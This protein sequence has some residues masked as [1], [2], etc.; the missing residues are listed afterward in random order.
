MTPE[1]QKEFETLF[2]LFVH[3]GWELFKREIQTNYSI[4]RDGTVDLDDKDEFLKRKGYVY[5]L[6]YALNF[7]ALIRNAYENKL[8]ENNEGL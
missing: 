8:Q 7:E 3:P 2:D 1:E 4:L 6:A 5:G